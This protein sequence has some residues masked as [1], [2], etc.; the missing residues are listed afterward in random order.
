[1]GDFSIDGRLG[2]ALSTAATASS[3][4]TCDMATLVNRSAGQLSEE[5]VQCVYS[6]LK[7]G[8]AAQDDMRRARE[9]EREERES[10]R[11]PR[12]GDVFRG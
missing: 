12:L 5:S 9:R 6:I 4:E 10:S 8:V 3:A 7:R 2:L 11:L 1:M